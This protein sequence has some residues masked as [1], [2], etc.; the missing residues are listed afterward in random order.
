MTR[1][2]VNR[3]RSEV[4]KG[5]RASP[6]PGPDPHV[7]LTRAQRRGPLKLGETQPSL[8]FRAGTGDTCTV[9]GEGMT[10]TSSS[11]VAPR[12]LK[13]KNH[14]GNLTSRDT[15]HRDLS[16]HRQTTSASEDL[17]RAI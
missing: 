3:I 12:T 14:Q 1:L 2:E 4:R 9:E 16:C 13:E 15:S 6:P 17:Q 8:C 11:H 10:F 5:G 7:L